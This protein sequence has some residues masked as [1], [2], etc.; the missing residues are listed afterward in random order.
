MMRGDIKLDTTAG[1]KTL[2]ELLKGHITVICGLPD[3]GKVCEEHVK[4][5]ID[6]AD[7][8]KDEGVK[9]VVV[10]AVDKASVVDGWL[11]E[12]YGDACS[13]VEAV[14]DDIGAFTRMLGV[15]I[16][17]PDRPQKTQRFSVL[18]DNGILLKMK[19]EESCG[20]VKDTDAE[21]ILG[22]FRDLKT[23]IA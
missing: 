14:G 1:T 3:M 5:Y 19:V 2:R 21:S 8:L 23:L 20:K 11:K 15:N 12:K 22:V 7:A 17:D 4:G 10:M 16:N 18:I 6:L 9:K 13:G